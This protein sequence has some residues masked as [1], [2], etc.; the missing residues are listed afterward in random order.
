MIDSYDGSLEEIYLLRQLK[1]TLDI[2]RGAGNYQILNEFRLGDQ[3]YAL[4]RSETDHP[5]D[6]QLFRVTEDQVDEI[7]NEQE[8]EG[9]AEA[10][11]E[12]LFQ[13]DQITR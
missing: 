8:W 1:Q 13:Q 10:I 9:I 12:Y 3:H 6:L 7:D 11:D 4:V 5:D 2:T